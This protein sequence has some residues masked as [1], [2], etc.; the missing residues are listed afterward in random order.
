M[1]ANPGTAS[2][3]PV[4]SAVERTAKVKV[5][6]EYRCE[7][8]TKPPYTAMTDVRARAANKYL[9]GLQLGLHPADPAQLAS[10]AEWSAADFY[11]DAMLP[12]LAFRRR[13]NSA[14]VS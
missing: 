14:V 6:G 10:F 13:R 8:A 12:G 2:V 9:W 1:T 3:R 5:L 7:R 4:T 11:A